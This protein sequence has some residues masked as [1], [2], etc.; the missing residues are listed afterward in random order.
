VLTG[1]FGVLFSQERARKRWDKPNLQKLLESGEQV[2]W[3][4]RAFSGIL[5]V[6]GISS[7]PFIW[8]ST[9]WDVALTERRLLAVEF[10][11]LPFLRQ[12][13]VLSAAWS[14]IQAAQLRIYTG[15]H[16]VVLSVQSPGFD[17]SFKMG[18]AAWHFSA[19]Q[20]VLL[21]KYGSAQI[22]KGRFRRGPIRSAF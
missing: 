1:N 16:S 4:D 20:D 9:F 13:R 21:R 18:N 6:P 12:R 3:A 11:I 22:L 8:G 14:E 2:V 5:G 17:K 19:I 7:M 15:W 10:L